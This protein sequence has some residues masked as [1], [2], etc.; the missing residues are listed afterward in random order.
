MTTPGSEAVTFSEIVHDSVAP[1]ETSDK[2]IAEPPLGADSVPKQLLEMSAGEANVILGGKLSVK[3]S[4]STGSVDDSPLVMVNSSVAVLPG[5]IVSG[6]NIFVKLGKSD[7]S[8]SWAT[9]MI[10]HQAR[11][12]ADNKAQR[13]RQ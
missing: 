1:K 5:P 7:D 3:A 12:I 11:Q 13:L 4:A 9:P 2:D 6:I 8:I 10:G